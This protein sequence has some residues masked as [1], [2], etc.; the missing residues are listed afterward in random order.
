MIRMNLKNE[1]N[2]ST[3]VGPN[4]PLSRIIIG[5]SCASAALA[6][7]ACGASSFDTAPPAPPE[8]K[9]KQLT[10]D[11][12]GPSDSPKESEPQDP[13]RIISLQITG[14]QPEAWWNNCL[15][16]E[17]DGKSFDIACT[18]DKDVKEKVVRIPIPEGVKCPVLDLRI[19]TFKNV[20]D[21]C[22][23]RSREGLECN[24][25]FESSPS[26][27]RKHSVA[28]DR[29]HFVLSEGKRDGAGTVFRAY[30]EDQDAE[31]IRSVKDDSSRAEALGID[32]NDAIFELTSPPELPFEISGAAG[33]KCPQ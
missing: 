4:I 1:L 12:L 11:P 27:V 24:G 32:F 9:P 17:L 23:E 5:V 3:R 10:T 13:K 6:L 21:A 22:K 26:F 33:T 7:W 16:I 8:R 14:V 18:K 31:A 25:P 28:E 30:F 29:V 20:G 2:K 15:K 19:E